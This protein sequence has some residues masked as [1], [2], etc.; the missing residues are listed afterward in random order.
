M[1]KGR[2]TIRTVPHDP[3]TRSTAASARRRIRGRQAMGPNLTD[4]IWRRLLG[5]RSCSSPGRPARSCRARSSS[6]PG[7]PRTCCSTV[8]LGSV[9]W[10][11]DAAWGWSAGGWLTPRSG[12]HD[13]IASA[14]VHGVAGRV[15][16]GGAVPPRAADRQVR[17]RR[18][19]PRHVQAAQ[20]APHAAGAD[21]DLHGLLRLL[22]GLPGDPVDR[23]SRAGLNI[24]LSPT[25]LG[26]DH[27]RDHDRLCRRIH[28]RLLRQPRA[29][30]SGRSPAASPA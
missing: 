30:R 12:F 3:P 15:H 26:V 11:L 13:A 17:H 29:T 4:H 22:R 20:P 7:S 27:V 16:A 28:G 25:T 23:R 1:E 24:Y 6:A 21:A 14:V 5:W 19:E 9:I 2:P 18:A 8:L 10:I